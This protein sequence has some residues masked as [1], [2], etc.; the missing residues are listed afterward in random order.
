MR[1]VTLDKYLFMMLSG[2]LNTNIM[3]SK[4]DN[5]SQKLNKEEM[6]FI[7]Y[8]VNKLPSELKN[9]IHKHDFFNFSKH[10]C[11]TDAEY[12]KDLKVLMN[13]FKENDIN[14]AYK[15]YYNYFLKVKHLLPHSLEKLFNDY[16]YD[17][18]DKDVMFYEK[19]DSFY[20]HVGSLRY[21][22]NT[23][24]KDYEFDCN[25]TI[26]FK[27]VKQH[28]YSHEDFT[29]PSSPSFMNGYFSKAQKIIGVEFYPLDNCLTET[30]IQ[31][32][33]CKIEVISRDILF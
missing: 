12:E 14:D 31:C 33:P 22:H 15:N 25:Y 29:K 24:P 3:F 11:K 6:D 16:N 27:D 5:I 13:W 4:V 17:F 7:E 21:E 26:H 23:N 18:S 9:I 19:E 2:Y 20:M 1:Y 8:T 32:Y 30:H 28:N 10:G